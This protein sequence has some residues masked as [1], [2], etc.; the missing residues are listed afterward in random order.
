M[1][2]KVGPALEY[3]EMLEESAQSQPVRPLLLAEDDK[4]PFEM[5]LLAYWRRLAEIL[6]AIVEMEAELELMEQAL[7]ARS[8]EF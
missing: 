3:F 8:G 4:A 7:T 1:A 6:V 2:S 5:A